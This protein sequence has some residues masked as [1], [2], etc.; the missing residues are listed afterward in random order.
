MILANQRLWCIARSKF[1]GGTHWVWCAQH[2][3]PPAD[4][5]C[6]HRRWGRR[7]STLQA[8]CSDLPCDAL[9]VLSLGFSMC[10]DLMAKWDV[11][12][13]SI[14]CRVLLAVWI[15]HHHCWALLLLP[16]ELW[17]GQYEEH[18][19]V[20]W[21]QW[22]CEYLLSRES[23]ASLS[24]IGSSTLPSPFR[25]WMDV[26]VFWCH[27][28]PFLLCSNYTCDSNWSILGTCKTPAWYRKQRQQLKRRLSSWEKL[29]DAFGFGRGAWQWFSCLS[30]LCWH[31]LQESSQRWISSPKQTSNS[32]I[33]QH[34]SIICHHRPCAKLS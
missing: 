18:R 8:H 4:W 29:S 28:L 32:S 21:H 25:A 31:F 24:R 19:S 34:Q 10:T 12:K 14:S 2:H 22:R 33:L 11:S 20:Q 9:Q 7:L 27:R 17:L 1:A 5:A 23:V 26:H 30:G 13:V 16:S 3:N 6:P 15:T